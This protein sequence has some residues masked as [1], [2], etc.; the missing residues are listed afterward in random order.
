MGEALAEE[1]GLGDLAENVRQRQK[2]RRI[3]PC[4]T[5]CRLKPFGVLV[6]EDNLLA[7]IGRAVEVAAPER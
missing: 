3:L 2:S 1:I 5:G 6:V 7:A 4:G